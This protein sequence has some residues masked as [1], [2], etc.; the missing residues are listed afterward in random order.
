MR[1][2]SLRLNAISATLLAGQDKNY[3]PLLELSTYSHYPQRERK[4]GTKKERETTT[5][6]FLSNRTFLTGGKE[7]ISNG[8]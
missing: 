3:E 6:L 7:D 1:Q 8:A 4:K 5:T 2:K